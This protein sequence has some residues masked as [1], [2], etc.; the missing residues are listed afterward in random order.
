[1]AKL[2][3]NNPASVYGGWDKHLIQTFHPSYK[4][5]KAESEKKYAAD[6]GF[7]ALFTKR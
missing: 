1:M 4:A 2:L 7:V 6:T 3:K 5:L